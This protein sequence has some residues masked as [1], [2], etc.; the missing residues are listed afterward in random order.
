MATPK[1]RPPLVNL[2]TSEA[3]RQ[4]LRDAAAARGVTVAGFIREALA[5]QGVA[6][7]C[8]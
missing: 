6:I 3:D 5:A 4:K 8:S 1:E 7:G 2:R